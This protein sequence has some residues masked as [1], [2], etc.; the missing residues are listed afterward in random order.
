MARKLY[1]RKILNEILW[2][3]KRHKKHF[4][5][6]MDLFFLSFIL[7]HPFYRVRLMPPIR[8][9]KIAKAFLMK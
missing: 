9:L 6:G 3:V 4:R 7:S 1:A 5:G 8:F 2:E